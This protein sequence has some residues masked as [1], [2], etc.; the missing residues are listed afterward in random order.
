[1]RTVVR[2]ACDNLTTALSRM[3]R[4]P[5]SWKTRSAV[6]KPSR[7]LVGGH[8]NGW[9]Q[10][11]SLPDA[12]RRPR[13]PGEGRAR[14]PQ[15]LASAGMSPVVMRGGGA[16]RDD[17]GGTARPVVDMAD[18]CLPCGVVVALVAVGL[19]ARSG[20]GDRFV[21]VGVRGHV[22]AGPVAQRRRTRGGALA[23]VPG[24]ACRCGLVVTTMDDTPG[25]VTDSRPAS[26]G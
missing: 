13:P 21:G 8:G 6:M 7:V 20:G 24:T 4:Q 14:R 17:S 19:G 23:H 16:A 12:C 25:M 5:G 9:A 15:R 11:R 2:F 26:G 18:P 10:G 1:M 3:V 22:G